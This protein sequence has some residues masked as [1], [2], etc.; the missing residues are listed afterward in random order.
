[1][2]REYLL[3]DKQMAQFIAHGY[4]SLSTDLGNDI[5]QKIFDE[6]RIIFEKEGNPG[7][8]LLPRVPLVNRVFKDPKIVGALI[9]TL[10]E[11]YYLQPHRHPHH[12]IANSQG[13]SMHQDGGKRWSHKTRYLLAFYYP[14]DTPLDLGPSG[15]IPG[16]HYFNSPEGAPIDAEIPLV[17]K[18]GTVTICDYDLWH[19]AMPNTSDRNRFM[20][21][22][23]FARMTEPENPTWNNEVREWV[24]VPSVLPGDDMD[25]QQMY[26]HRWY[27]HCGEYHT[28]KRIT[29]KPPEELLNDI[30]GNNERQA[31]AAA[32]EIASL[33]GYMVKEL[34]ELLDSDSEMIRRNSAYALSAIGAPSVKLLQQALQ[35]GKIEK[36]AEAATI[37]GDLGKISAD[38]VST[39]CEI[40]SDDE[41][42]VRR[43]CIEALG[44]IR[45]D[46]ANVI[47][48]LI[49]AL[50]DQ[51][52]S[53]RQ[54]G[55]MAIC[56]YGAS[57]AKA[58][59]AV[60]EVLEDQN[61]YVRADALQALK[62]IGTVEAIEELIEQLM[63]ARWCPLTSP[64]S[65]F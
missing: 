45:S 28:P 8:N 15:V 26:A 35:T 62:R 16:S 60:K 47:P 24:K 37:L 18:A 43:R 41:E 17:A 6:H 19:R 65:T 64:E 54:A 13:Q 29:K 33:G 38:A 20:I 31:I 39:L 27:W 5:H 22:F 25:W 50:R 36:K 42:L 44:L 2:N 51:H 46:S 14:Q 61:R 10:G 12:N 21:K 58:T 59:P 57:A 23:L 11:D 7:N 1:M 40:S 9:S 49:S 32:Y 56:R 48:T 30:A 34:I 53:V 3:T 52:E 63:P 4:V 55:V